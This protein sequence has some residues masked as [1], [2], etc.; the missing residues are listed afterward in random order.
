MTQLATGL[1]ERG[2]D[3]D[4]YTSQPTYQGQ[5]REK[6]PPEEIHKGVRIRRLWGTQLNKES[7]LGRITNWLSFFVSAFINL[8]FRS[9]RDEILLMVSNPP[10]I[11]FLGPILNLLRG[12]EYVLIIYDIYPDMAVNLGFVSS[13]SWLVRLWNKLDRWLYSRAKRIVVLGEGMKKTVIEKGASDLNRDK[14]K[15]IHNWEDPDFIIPRDKSD[16]SFALENG[17]EDQ[18][19]TLYS[20][21]LGQHHDLE[22]LVEAAKLVENL[23]IKLVFIGDGAKKSKLQKMVD[24]YELGN[25]DFHPYQPK[26]KLPETLTC[27]DISIV[28]EDKRAEGLCVSSKLYSSLAA[29]QAILGLVGKDSD[30]AHVIEN[31]DCGLR[32]DQGDAEKVAEH[33]KFWLENENE[34]KGMGENAR[35]HFEENFTLENSVDKYLELLKEVQ[36]EK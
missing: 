6:L 32:A 19:T 18:L 11:Q 15:I 21:N 4:A 12:Q 7:A 13:D 1:Q 14:I 23:P 22:T 16:N 27:A 28:S 3:V 30:V 5:E 17:Y 29:G 34:L 2:F 33:L 35:E 36:E 20:G 26:E 9:D 8:L 10:I 31:G 24:Q 25:V